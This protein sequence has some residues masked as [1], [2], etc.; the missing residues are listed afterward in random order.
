MDFLP[1][2]AAA[3][4]SAQSQSRPA[5]PRA[6]ARAAPPRPRPSRPSPSSARALARARWRSGRART[7]R[8]GRMPATAA[9]WRSV[10]PTSASA[11]ALTPPR[12]APRHSSLRS[13]S[14]L[15]HR[16][17]LPFPPPP[18]HALAGRARSDELRP[19]QT[20]PSRHELPLSLAH[21][22]LTSISRGKLH[23]PANRSPEFRPSS[24]W[25]SAPWK[26]RLRLFF[27]L[28]RASILFASSSRCSDTISRAAPWPERSS[29][30]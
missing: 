18:P 14:S 7:P 2:R 29:R 21:P 22:V 27:S 3:S 12:A 9:G 24:P 13:A 15:V 23:S 4:G 8:G 10:A 16:A 5:S 25:F 28:T 26:P 6:R 17:Q 11:H 1:S 19:P 30:R 20:S